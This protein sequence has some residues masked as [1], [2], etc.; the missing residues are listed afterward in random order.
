MSITRIG[1][2]G[3]ETG[4]YESGFADNGGG[5]YITPV[6]A[7]TGSRC[8]C[9]PTSYDIL[10][11]GYA[12]SA[13]VRTGFYFYAPT[14][15]LYGNDPM[16]MKF[17]AGGTTLVHIYMEPASNLRFWVNGAVRATYTMSF[18]TWYHFGVTL[19]RH[20]SSGWASFYVNGEQKCT[21]SG[22]TGSSNPTLTEWG[23]G[24][25]D[26]NE[27]GHFYDDVYMDTMSGET[28]RN[29]PLRRFYY[30]TPDG[31]GNYSDWIG[32]DG[33]STN[34][35]VHVDEVPQN[36]SDYVYTEDVDQY[37]SYTM[38]SHTL[39]STQRFIRLIPIV[40]AKDLGTTEQ[41]ALGTRYSST[42]LIGSAQ[43]PTTSYAQYDES[44]DSKPG[45][46]DW[47]QT[48][49]DGVELVLKSTGS[50]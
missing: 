49:V 30:L 13:Q 25:N 47:D 21:W 12:A 41:I 28:D 33:D 27:N 11:R 22:N 18:D 35:Y 2:I 37:D 43:S 9:A 14:G 40:R 10:Y 24:T 29:P 4:Q 38:T 32:S 46:G 23:T 26:W 20:T 50:F 42:D 36:D 16:V 15:G 1:Q 3:F 31:T 39:T 34:N 48:S 17:K 19:N 45:G 7:Y 6:R 5:G 44:Q 8:Y